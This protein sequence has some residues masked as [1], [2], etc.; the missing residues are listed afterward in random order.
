MQ[1]ARENE[2]W[3]FFAWFFLDKEGLIFIND[4]GEIGRIP[5]I[6]PKIIH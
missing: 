1:I 5:F 2:A 3:S 6:L 4:Y